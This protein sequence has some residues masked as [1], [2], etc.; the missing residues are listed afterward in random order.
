MKLFDELVELLSPTSNYTNL[1]NYLKKSISPP[2]IP[3]IG[4][5][6]TDLTFL[7]DGNTDLLGN[8]IN[9]DKRR[10]IATVISDIKQY[11]QAKYALAHEPV[12]REFVLK[13]SEG[14]DEN[15]CYKES[16]RVEPRE[17]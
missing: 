11:Q 14:F 2:C 15:K 9:F 5:Y 13:I 12:L 1:R 17:G 8:L 6:L 3:Y 4:V 7:E 10:R 16:L